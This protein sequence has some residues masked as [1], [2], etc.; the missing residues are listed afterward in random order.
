MTDKPP[1]FHGTT[2]SQ[3]VPKHLNALHTARQA[4]TKAKSSE[5][6]HRALRY[7]IGANSENYES[8]DKVLYKRE[9][10]NKWKGPGFII[11]QDGKIIFV[12]HGGIYVRVSAS[13]IIKLNHEVKI[14]PVENISKINSQ[15][16]QSLQLSLQKKIRKINQDDDEVGEE[17]NQENITNGV[18]IASSETYDTTEIPQIVTSETE[19]DRNPTVLEDKMQ[20]K[21]MFLQT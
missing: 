16:A 17:D 3:V 4:F 21:C 10:S 1:A 9:N 13:W 2:I 14:P 15:L 11:G 12:C 6:I 8:G 20:S 19:T 18:A 5:R 7:K